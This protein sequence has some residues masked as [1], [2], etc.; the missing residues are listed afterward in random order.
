M[1][2]ETLNVLKTR[3]SVR[4]YKPDQVD[5]ET[6]NAILEAGT[7]A[8][9]GMGKQPSVIVAVQSPEDRKAVMELNKKAR[10]G[11]G[12]PY[13]GAPA[14]LL[15]LTDGSTHTGVEDASCVP[16]TPTTARPQSCWCWRTAISPA[17]LW[18]TAPACSTP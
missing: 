13:Y 10:G 3:R 4:K 12:D 2:N 14:I 5:P 8:P 1:Q 18:R 6:L 15:V 16:A 11:S 17:P 7:Y 9:S